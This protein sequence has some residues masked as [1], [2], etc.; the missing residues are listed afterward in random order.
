[1]TMSELPAPETANPA[2]L[3]HGELFRASSRQLAPDPLNLRDKNVLLALLAA[4]AA[5]VAL[6]PVFR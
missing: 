3:D 6:M 5:A 1:M 2:E 4:T